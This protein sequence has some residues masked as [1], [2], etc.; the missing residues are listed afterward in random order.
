MV[1]LEKELLLY[2]KRYGR[3]EWISSME[4]FICLVDTIRIRGVHD[5][6]RLIS[7]KVIIYDRCRE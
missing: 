7:F 5:D 4:Q 2:I 6:D 3:D 1:C